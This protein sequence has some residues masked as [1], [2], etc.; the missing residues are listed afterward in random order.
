MYYGTPVISSNAASLP[1]VGGDAALYFDPD[2]PNELSQLVKR[3]FESN[4]LQRE[5]ISKG[6]K[7]VGR[8]T[9]ETFVEEIVAVCKSAA[10]IQPHQQNSK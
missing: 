6:E 1:E 4:R 3:V 5:L 9:C 8:F 10:E 2:S 7:N